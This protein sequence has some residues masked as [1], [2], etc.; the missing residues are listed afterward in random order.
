MTDSNVAIATLYA[1][2]REKLYKVAAATL[3]SQ[4]GLT[5]GALDVVQDVFMELKANFPCEEIRSWEA[6]LVRR[7][8]LRAIDLGRKQ[9]MKRRGPAIDGGY[10]PVDPTNPGFVEEVQTRLDAA[11]RYQRT[12]AAMDGLSDA[13]RRVVEG[14]VIGS[15]DRAGM[16]SQLGVSGPRVSQLKAS[17][18]AKIRDQMEE[19]SNE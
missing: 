18:L 2:H 7:T 6:L 16:A 3:R 11:E 1:E 4:F 12:R 9:H 14:H 8:K 17:A 19:E 10:E 15:L 5:D 13:E